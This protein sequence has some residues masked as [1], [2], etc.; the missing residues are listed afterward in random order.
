[1]SNCKI[2]YFHHSVGTGG[3]PRSL[4]YLI[5][6]L[7]R[8]KYDPVVVVPKKSSNAFVREIFEAANATVLEHVDI[9]PFHGSQVAPYHSFRKRARALWVYPKLVRA[10]RQLVGDVKPDIVHLNSTCLVGAAKGA[11]Q[12]IAGVPTIA[13]VREPLLE[14]WWGR[15]LASLNRKH[16]DYFIGIDQYGID[17]LQLKEND[18]SVIFNFVDRKKFAPVNEEVRAKY[19]ESFGWKP[20]QTVFLSLARIEPYNGAAEL[21]ELVGELDSRLDRSATFVFAGFRETDTAYQT[22][23]RTAI[24]LSSRCHAL[25]FTEDVVKAIN[26]ADVIVVPYITP[27]SARSVFEA[28]AIGKPALVSKVPNLEELVVDGKT[29]LVFDWKLPESIVDLVNQLCCPIRETLG[30]A[31]FERAAAE[32]DQV[33]NTLR[34]EEVY[35]KL[36]HLEDS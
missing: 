9:Q 23:A 10:A 34:T 36:L 28:A 29:G 20:G 26:A 24:G 3:A 21:A 31:A 19:R 12:A 8:T 4:A 17:S 35:R 22:R 30:T 15:N 16:V 13:H 14:N 11:H 18:A 27:H 33:T 6:G 7:D 2:L 1:M 5:A 32:F 25:Q